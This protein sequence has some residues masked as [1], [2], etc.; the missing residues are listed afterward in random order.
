MSTLMKSAASTRPDRAT[1]NPGQWLTAQL[2]FD[3]E[4]DAPVDG[5]PAHL[6]WEEVIWAAQQQGLAG[7]LRERLGGQ[8]LAALPSQ[9]RALLEVSRLETSLNNALLYQELDGW[10]ARFAAEQIPVIVL[11]GAALGMLLYARTDLRPM[12]DVDLL[13]PQA[14]F[15]RAAQL[16]QDSGYVRSVDSSGDML[17]CEHEFSRTLAAG[18]VIDGRSFQHAGFAMDGF[19][20][21][22]DSP[23]IG[24]KQ[25][26]IDLHWHLVNS[27]YYTQHVPVEW[28]WAHTTE[29][30]AGRAAAL[31]FSVQAQLLHLSSHHAFHHANRG[32]LWLYDIAGLIQRF[33]TGIDWD[34]TIDT[35]E[36]FEWGQSLAIAVRQAQ[37]I[38]GV[39]IFS[40]VIARLARVPVTRQESLT[41][42]FA[43]NLS[44]ILVNGWNEMDSGRRLRY[45]LHSLW[46]PA[47]YMR[48]RYHI[49][50]RRPL[51]AAY[52]RRIGRG[53]YRV[54][55]DL[56]VGVWGMRIRNLR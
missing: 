8:Q 53:L 54:P 6:R 30:R 56:L 46:P 16:L 50:G 31:V 21:G 35:A 19:P 52:L 41:R 1:L 18:T 13:V 40:D 17:R 11:K 48:A 23:C 14:D 9:A 25:L 5:L 29:V 37:E 44:S 42:A 33:G 55:Q 34:L 45:W 20:G 39:V 49:T 27:S 7:F 2:R 47:E 12:T 51:L 15:A 4:P 10:L 22:M 36:R 3:R 24:E 38:F 26:R 32:F 43:G 28:F